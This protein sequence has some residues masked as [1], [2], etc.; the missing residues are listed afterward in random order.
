MASRS[1][2]SGGCPARAGD[3]SLDVL[4]KQRT[5]AVFRDPRAHVAFNCAARSCPP[6]GA[7]AWARQPDLDRALDDAMRAFVS[8]STR[9]RIDD[10]H[11]TL[12]LS[13]IFDWYAADFGGRAGVLRTVS[14]YLGRDVTAYRVEY[15][16]Y[17]WSLNA[18]TYPDGSRP[19]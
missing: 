15:L 9:N 5:L 14:R 12:R 3:I 4:E 16:D 18:A 6:L 2:G 8:D 17:D 11:R 13:R 19:R 1:S 10:A 7:R